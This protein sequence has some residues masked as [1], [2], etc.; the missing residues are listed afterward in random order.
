[1]ERKFKRGYVEKGYR[2]DY[3]AII[4]KVTQSNEYGT[5]EDI[6][7]DEQNRY[8]GYISESDAIKD[9]KEFF[10]VKEICDKDYHVIWSKLK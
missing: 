10:K 8:G 1:M 3:V 6:D 2:G 5:W 7:E 4:T 9:L